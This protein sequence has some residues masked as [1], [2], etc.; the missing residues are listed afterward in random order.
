[1]KT[2]K[3]RWG[4]NMPGKKGQHIPG[5]SYKY[6]EGLFTKQ[7]AERDA[8]VKLLEKFPNVTNVLVISDGCFGD[9]IKS[10]YHAIAIGEIPDE[11]PEDTDKRINIRTV[12]ISWG[13]NESG[14]NG[15]HI[16]GQSYGYGEGLFTR[17]EAERDARIKLLEK[18]P[19]ATNVSVL[20]VNSERSFNC[21]TNDWC[22]KASGEIEDI[23]SE[24]S[25]DTKQEYTQQ[26][27]VYSNSSEYNHMFKAFEVALR[28]STRLAKQY[29]LE[30]DYMDSTVDDYIDPNDAIEPDEHTI[31]IKTG[32]NIDTAP[33]YYGIKIVFRKSN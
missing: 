29:N 17:Y 10:L 24:T 3:M 7:E 26:L 31:V 11:S 18:F 2:V 9:S 4:Y 19:N 22:A 20:S 13:Y 6:K 27:V 28:E 16:P 12:E 8:R 33:S 23:D 30:I 15:K 25:E 21:F 5:H 32:I 14:E 1:M